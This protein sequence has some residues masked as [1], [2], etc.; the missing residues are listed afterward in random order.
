MF[1]EEP[2]SILYHYTTQKGLLGI[3]QSKTIWATDILY[4]NDTMELKY[5]VDL[6]LD[7]IKWR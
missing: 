1:T 4:L 7:M 6:T 3:I 2:P 5:A